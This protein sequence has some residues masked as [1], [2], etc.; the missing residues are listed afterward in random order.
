VGEDRN[1]LKGFR[2]QDKLPPI[3]GESLVDN[4][5]IAAANASA[6]GLCG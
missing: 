3:R 2:Y 5:R 6:T 4:M 1:T